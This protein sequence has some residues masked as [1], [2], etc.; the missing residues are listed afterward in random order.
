MILRA[1]SVR[2]RPRAAAR[3]VGLAS[4]ALLVSLRAQP[5]SA[6]AV[7]RKEQLMSPSKKISGYAPLNGL[8]LYYEIE[9]TGRPLVYIPPVFGFAGMK[10]FPVL[11]ER[12]AVI[13][14]DLQGQGRTADIPERP[15][16]IEQHASDVVA[17]LD[18]LKIEKADFLGESYGAATALMIAL[19]HPGRVER[20]ATYGGAFGPPK[21][22]HNLT[23]LRFERPPTP[24]SPSFAFQRAEYERVAPAPEYWTRLWQKAVAMPWD[25]FSD[26]QLAAIK[27]PVLLMA[28]DHDFVR[29]EHTLAVF[30]RLPT[31][32]VAVIPDASHFALFSEP[33]KI[34]PV[35]QH[36]LEKPA[37][38]LPLA[39]AEM[40]YRPGYSR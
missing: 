30:K 21:E 1:V 3:I 32:E 2:G 9:G 23:M 28:G 7:A 15:F 29:I 38:R 20:V 24:D 16:S 12:H 5:P 8:R 33:E 4:I 25:G 19:R 18:H 10:S 27:A 40:G 11:S 31:A 14:M 35:V 34:I 39:T 17:L 13:T 6:P 26:E 37:A 36:F 22:A